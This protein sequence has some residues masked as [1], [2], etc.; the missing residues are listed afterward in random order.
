M[1][2]QD[3]QK[4]QKR[5]S[6][7]PKPGVALRDQVVSSAK[8]DRLQKVLAAAGLGSRRQCEELIAAGRVEVDRHVVTELGTR[9]DPVRQPIRVDGVPLVTARLVYYAVNKPVG[10]LCTN[11]DCSSFLVPR[12][13]FLVSFPPSPFRLPP[14]S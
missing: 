1:P 10:V 9:V 6:T 4:R 2:T 14:L 7:S 5:R 11:R 13:S 8:P 12:S 3:P